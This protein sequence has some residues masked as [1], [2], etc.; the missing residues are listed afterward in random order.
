MKKQHIIIS[1]VS[2]VILAGLLTLL[3]LLTPESPEQQQPTG[4]QHQRPVNVHLEDVIGLELNPRGESMFLIA[5]ERSENVSA[6]ILAPGRQGFSYNAQ[7]LSNA[8][9]AA[10]LMPGST[11]LAEN[12][13]NIDDFG[14]DD[15]I[16]TWTLHLKD[17][18]YFTFEMGDPA[19]GGRGIYIREQGSRDV[20]ILPM[21]AAGMFARMEREFRSLQFFP[22]Y[23]DN[24]EAILSI[25]HYHLEGSLEPFGIER[26]DEEVAMATMLGANFRFTSPVELYVNAWN[27][28]NLFLQGILSINFTAVV[29]D[30]PDEEDLKSFGLDNPYRLSLLD[31]NE[32]EVT[33]LIGD[34]HEFG[35]RYL[36]LEGKPTVFH[37]RAGDYSFLDVPYVTLIHNL[38]W[39]H[40]IHT[41]DTVIYSFG[42]DVF[43]L[44]YSNV[45]Y[46]NFGGMQL[47]GE[48]ISRDNGSFI[49]AHTLQLPV[50]GRNDESFGE[51]YGFIKITLLDGTEHRLDFYVL[52]SHARVLGFTH[53]DERTDLTMHRNPIETNLTSL[54]TIAS[55]GDI[56]WSPTW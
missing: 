15:P 19:G 17:E 50:H 4:P 52:D 33:L 26:L 23:A 6:F 3:L 9:D 51:H 27:F 11:L 25:L 41:V 42:D 44:D 2:A 38:F 21:N 30:D 36:M 46:E 20:F 34:E 5:V 28:N 24:E 39:V 31:V 7:A 13:D 37:D 22:D 43:T 16:M 29:M 56:P 1:A 48:D 53:N 18:S 12:V 35:G 32:W 54:A 40:D 55:G 49:Y 14:F 45:T 8:V 47:N 10:V